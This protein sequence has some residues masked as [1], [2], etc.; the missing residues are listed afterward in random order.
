MII[1]FQQPCSDQKQQGA[2][3]CLASQ[4][5]HKQSCCSLVDVMLLSFFWQ[6]DQ[7]KLQSPCAPERRALLDPMCE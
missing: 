3:L 5:I 7:S 6:M 2:H 4:V 1:E